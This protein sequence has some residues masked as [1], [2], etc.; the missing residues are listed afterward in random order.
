LKLAAL[1]E[2]GFVVSVKP[3]LNCRD[4]A[5]CTDNFVDSRGGIGLT[6]ESGWHKDNSSFTEV[7]Q[8]TM[9][10]LNYLG[11]TPFDMVNYN[12]SSSISSK[13]LLIEKAIIPESDNFSYSQDYKNFDQVSKGSLI[14]KDG[15]IEI[16]A[17]KDLYLLFVKEDIQKN[18]TVGFLATEI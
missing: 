16:L 4:L 12:S 10:Y 7:L 15:E 5:S 8:K 13:H 6:Y 9:V 2:T 1:F 3:D 11:V 17:E 14:A 18:K